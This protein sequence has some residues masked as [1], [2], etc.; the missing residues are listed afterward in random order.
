MACNIQLHTES[1]VRQIH[2]GH[3]MQQPKNR[4]KLLLVINH[5]YYHRY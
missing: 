4:R 1:L 3:G 2:A 5:Y